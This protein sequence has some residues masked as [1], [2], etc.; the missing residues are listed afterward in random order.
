MGEGMKI[1]IIGSGTCIPAPHRGNFGIL[2]IVNNIYIL[3]DGG[4]GVLR[5][6]ADFGYD[7]R[8]I[9][10]IFYTHLHPDHTMD[11]IP[12]LFALRNDPTLTE[13]KSI[14]IYGPEGFNELYKKLYNI[15]GNYLHDS[16]LYISLNE[17][18]E[19]E[20]SPFPGLSL[21]TA[22]TKHAQGSIG[23]KFSDSMG[24]S[25]VI[26]G[27][28][29]VCQ[30]ICDLSK[31]ADLLITEC[32]YP[33]DR[34]VEGHLTP[35]LVLEIIHRAKPKKLLLT[36][37]YPILEVESVISLISANYEGDLIIGEDGLALEV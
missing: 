15:Y 9:E 32:S 2:I 22:F 31:N 29:D 34:Y 12:F 24:K 35:S 25:V 17:I 4:S 13:R 18:G 27:D 1:V 21:K 19:V 37:F 7:Y 16:K 36:H 10:Y 3:L 8:K 28:T 14:K 33:D 23:Y 6:I 30:E 5:K 11:L 20:F 26:T